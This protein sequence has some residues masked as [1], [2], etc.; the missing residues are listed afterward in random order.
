MK[1]VNSFASMCSGAQFQYDLREEQLLIFFEA[2]MEFDPTR[3]MA[4]STYLAQRVKWKCMTHAT[5]IFKRKENELN[6]FTYPST[7][8]SP[9]RATV[10][11]ERVAR[12]EEFIAQKDDAKIQYIY[13]NRVTHAGD[14][15]MSWQ[16]IGNH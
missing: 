12:W 16:E 4:F 6:E 13:Q 10:A 15:P 11:K 5:R 8:I 3:G 7:D 2:A 14:K 1:S 9:D